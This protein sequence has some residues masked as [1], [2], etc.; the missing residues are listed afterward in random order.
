MS[1]IILV[2]GFILIILYLVLTFGNITGDKYSIEGWNNFEKNMKNKY[3]NIDSITAERSTP[4]IFG[5]NIYINSQVE[6]IE[7]EKIFFS[8]K[9]QIL[10]E[11]MFEGL[12]RYHERKYKHNFTEIIIRIT[13]I[14]NKDYFVYGFS[15]INMNDEESKIVDFKSWSIYYNNK[16]I[17]EYQPDP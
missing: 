5:I 1:K 8:A 2:L 15:S 9:N 11:K 10:T 6:L 17:K 12:Q 7:A 14:E 4:P 3:P 13:Y 16:F